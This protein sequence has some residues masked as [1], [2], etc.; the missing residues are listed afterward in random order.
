MKIWTEQL[1]LL[2]SFVDLVEVQQK[3]TNFSEAE[4]IMMFH[5]HLF[6]TT[7]YNIIDQAI[8]D[9]GGQITEEAKQLSKEDSRQIAFNILDSKF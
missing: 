3:Y 6:A 7:V 8:I 9:D 2:N 4:T 1:D 5:N